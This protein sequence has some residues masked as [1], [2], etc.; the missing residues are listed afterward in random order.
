MSPP[1]LQSTAVA[2]LMLLVCAPAYA[3]SS[4]PD[5]E[6]PITSGLEIGFRSG[7][8]DRGFLLSDRPVIQPVAWLSRDRAEFSAWSNFT[9]VETTDGARP[10]ILELELTREFVWRDLSIAPALRMYFYRDPLSP[11][12][13]RSLESWWYLSY[14][15]GPLRLFTNHSL[16]VLTYRG[17]YFGDAGI[18][19]EQQLLDR[20]AIGG[21]LGA[22]WASAAFND[23]YVGVA[24]S[25][26]NHVNAKGW[27]TAYVTDRLY[28][29]PYFELNATLDRSVRA[30]HIQPTYFLVGVAIGGD[31]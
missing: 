25:A 23:S 30:E 10:E 11:F 18:E 9:L 28:I 1:L 21:S 16:D 14:D 15:L 7:H 8:A 26:L 12:S 22:G 19:S 13:T 2:S 4:A 27:V 5:E 3:Q 20:I 17:A 31:F 24:K 6:R 29:G